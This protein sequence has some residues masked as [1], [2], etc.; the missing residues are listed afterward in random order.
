[1]KILITYDVDKRHDEVKT[2]LINGGFGQSW[3]K[4]TM[5]YY[6]PETT[7]WHSDLSNATNGRELFMDIISSLNDEQ[8]P[9]KKIDV[10]RL[11]VVV[12]T[13]WAG[14]RGADHADEASE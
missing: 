13:G 10:L 6:L 9:E 5:T 8:S 4:D 1:M 11:M 7:V 14:N 12:F 3:K 2:A